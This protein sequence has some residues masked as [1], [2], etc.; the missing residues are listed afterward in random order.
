MEVIKKQI[1]CWLAAQYAFEGIKTYMERDLEPQFFK[2][3]VS[4]FENYFKDKFK[5]EDILMLS[6]KVKQ[7][8]YSSSAREFYGSLPP[9]H[10]KNFSGPSHDSA[11]WSDFGLIHEGYEFKIDRNYFNQND[12]EDIVIKGNK[13]DDTLQR[14]ESSSERWNDFLYQFKSVDPLTS[15][16]Y[17]LLGRDIERIGYIYIIR[18][19]DSDLYKLGF[20]EDP[21]RRLNQLQTGNGK[22]LNLVGYF[23]C[24]DL[25][26]ETRLHKIFKSS[27]KEGEWFSLT[28]EQATN[29]L[30]EEW[31]AANFCI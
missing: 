4:V 24:F 2:E 6:E 26:Q 31:R 1:A 18:K 14:V 22:Q 7:E 5:S 13:S 12:W 25:Q 30:D 8:I 11:V 27:R 10:L 20:S 21:Q 3:T 9:P 16:N 23:D 17:S 29:I 28:T 15:D 19:L